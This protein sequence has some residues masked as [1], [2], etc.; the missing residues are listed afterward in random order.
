MSKTALIVDDSTT[1]RRMVG[2]T[3]REAGF[4]VVEGANGREGLG[5]LETCGV[6]IIVTDVHMPVMDG[7][8]MVQ[9]VRERPKHRFTP[10]LILTTES[11]DEMK[12]RG[13]EA[14]ASGWIVKPFNPK[15]LREVIYRLLRLPLDAPLESKST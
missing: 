1:M 6:D 13:K 7:L 3:L 2:L 9:A 8:A 12:R 11:G 15:Q 14:G 4:E 10:I 5:H